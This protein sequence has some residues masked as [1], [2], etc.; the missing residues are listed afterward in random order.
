MFIFQ[1]KIKKNYEIFRNIENL[2]ILNNIY[3]YIYIYI[4]MIRHE[5]KIIVCKPNIDEYNNQTNILTLPIILSNIQLSTQKFN[6][7]VIL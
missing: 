6:A 1:T 7:T 5:S 3:I 4:Y 2:F